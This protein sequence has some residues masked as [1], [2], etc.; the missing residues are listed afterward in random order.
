[1]SGFDVEVE[2][3]Q[4]VTLAHQVTDA[5]FALDRCAHRLQGLNVAVYGAN[6]HLQAIGDLG[7]GDDPVL[8]SKY[9]NNLE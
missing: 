3:R 1:M 5:G 4:I 6:R 8:A 9:L 2:W 7:C